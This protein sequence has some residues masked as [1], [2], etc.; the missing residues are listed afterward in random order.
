MAELGLVAKVR[1][2]TRATTDSNHDKP[3]VPDLL[4]RQSDVKYPSMAWVMDIKHIATR[5][6]WLYLVV[7]QDGS[8]LEHR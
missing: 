8:R 6:D 1:R 2:T 5:E 7:W 4:G 3:V